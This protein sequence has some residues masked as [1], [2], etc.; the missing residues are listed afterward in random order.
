MGRAATA[1]AL[2]SSSL[3]K[4]LLLVDDERNVLL[5]MRR[6]FRAAGFEVDCATEREEAEALLVETT[7]YDAVVVDLRITAGYGPDGL[8]LIGCAREWCP[9]AGIVVLTAFGSAE[10]QAEAL[11]LG[12]DAFFHKPAPLA[13]VRDAL[14]TL[15]D[16]ASSG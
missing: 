12:A 3:V 15:L 4:R 13:Q 1:R 8:R 7:P 16:A 9:A 11:R 2:L 10:V 6:Y 5:G 14:E